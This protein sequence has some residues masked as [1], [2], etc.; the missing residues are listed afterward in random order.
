MHSLLPLTPV[1][2]PRSAFD[3]CRCHPPP[4]SE[5][6]VES[7]PQHSAIRAPAA[8]PP[9]TIQPRQVRAPHSANWAR[10]RG[11]IRR[12]AGFESRP[13]DFT[14]LD[15]SVGNSPHQVSE[16]SRHRPLTGGGSAPGGTA[17]GDT[18]LVTCA[19]ARSDRPVPTALHYEFSR[20]RHFIPC[21]GIADR[22]NS[23]SFHGVE[24]DLERVTFA[25]LP[26]R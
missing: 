20:S 14:D 7:N 3:N 21:Q 6:S 2:G 9:P 8:A 1:L 11:R 24:N 13:C 18:C 19:S 15:C 22:G 26:G 23:R 25:A 10:Q 4:P 17:E 5:Q 12:R 16:L